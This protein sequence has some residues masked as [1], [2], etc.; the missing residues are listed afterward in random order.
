M[1]DYKVSKRIEFGV[2]WSLEYLKLKTNS[3]YFRHFKYFRHSMYFRHFKY[4]RHSEY[5]RHFKYF[6]I[7]LR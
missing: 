6:L 4:F 7:L 2:S 3:K 5:F 1:M